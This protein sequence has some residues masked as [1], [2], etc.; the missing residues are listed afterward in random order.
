MSNFNKN[1]IKETFE[2]RSRY[3]KGAVHPCIVEA[4]S[5]THVECVAPNNGNPILFAYVIAHHDS[6][7]LGFNDAIEDKDKK[8]IF[9]DRLLKKMGDKHSRI[10]LKTINDNELS[11][12]IRDDITT[13]RRYDTNR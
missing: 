1:Q 4:D 2:T 3:I 6:V 9:S 5:H 13:I 12:D 7:T 10:E 11:N 8:Q